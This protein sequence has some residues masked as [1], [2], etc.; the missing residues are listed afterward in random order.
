MAYP[1]PDSIFILDTDASDRSRGAELSQIQN[2]KNVV[3]SYAS[4]VL[5]STQMKYC[6]T[7]KELLAILAFIRQYRHYLLGNLFIIRT[8]HKSLRWLLNFKSIEG[9]LARWIEELSQYNMLIQHRAG[10]KHA[11]ADAL[12]RIPNESD[13]HNTE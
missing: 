1:D 2:S 4:K 3:I 12:S 6:T 8:D 9:Q 5:S 11:N 10:K 13:V 7:R